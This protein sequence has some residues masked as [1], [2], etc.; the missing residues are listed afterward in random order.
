MKS[1]MKLKGSEAGNV[2]LIIGGGCSVN[3]F[4]FDKL[5]DDIKRMSV[6][7]CFVDTRL[8]Y[9]I[10]S[11]PFFIE[12]H[13]SMAIP[14][15]CKVIGYQ[16]FHSE[17]TDYIF[18]F[19]EIQMGFHS[20]FY[21]LQ[22][23]E[24]LGFSEIYLIGYDYCYGDD[25]KLHYYEGNGKVGI[26]DGEKSLYSKEMNKGL[27]LKDFEHKNWRVPIFNCNPDSCLNKFEFKSLAGGKP[28]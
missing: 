26:T 27:W 4:D 23:A 28:T 13:R 22:I 8:D 16:R 19:N 9:L 1:I 20:G 12:N 18:N 3:N 17:R 21:A 25:G 15:N 6:N 10:Y 11:D 14:E 24:L 7:W 5:P 2:C